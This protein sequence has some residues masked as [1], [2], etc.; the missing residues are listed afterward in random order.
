MLES[1]S[2]SR[3]QIR[4]LSIERFRGIESLTWIPDEGVN[5]ILGGGDAGKSTILDAI[6]LLL[7]PS[8]TFTLTEADYWRREV[9]KEFCIEAVMSIP[10]S[11]GLHSQSKNAWPWMWNGADAIV[12]DIEAK[13]SPQ[14]DDPVFRVRV[15]GTSDFDLLFEVRQPNDDL[16]HFSV[17]VRRAVGLV[18]LSSDDRNDRDLRLIQGS[19]LDR[20]LSDKTLRSRLGKLLG[21]SDVEAQLT[22]SAKQ[23]LTELDAA[24]AKRTLPNEL[25]LGL[26][27][28][29]GFSINALIGLTAKKDDVE[30]PLAVWGAG[31]RRLAALEVAAIHHGDNP[32]TVVDEAERGLEPYR[33]RVL[34]EDLEKSQSQVFLTTHSNAVLRAVDTASLWYMDTRGKVGR[35]P[36]KAAAHERRD[37]AIFLSRFA[38]V[39]EGI[40]EVGFVT[41]LLRRAIGDDLQRRGVWI[42]DAGGNDAAL[43][44]LDG[45]SKSGLKFAGFADDEGTHP[46]RWNAL[47]QTMQERLF[48]W[49]SGCLEENIIRTLDDSHLEQLIEDPTGEETGTRLRTLAFR[50]G[51]EDK[52]FSSIAAQAPDLKQ[53]I[54]EAATGTVPSGRV[55]LDKGEKKTYKN[56]AQCWFKNPKGGEELVA[57]V[58][59]LGLWPTL[60]PDLMPF[61]NSIRAELALEPIADLLP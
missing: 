27:G 47:K 41:A 52:T 4:K 21:A 29:Q 16:D 54:I 2:T 25:G 36:K 10:E 57:K 61:L 39:A 1:M 11:C 7:H 18:R 58:L 22:P 56:H 33:Q 48:R 30:L 28:T 60:R 5:V 13:G 53:L 19:A 9:D 17:A 50:L 34:V 51:I 59:K 49:K 8:N 43:D 20:L 37:P 14:N 6:S 26:S 46:G 31:T 32:I 3:P 44:L 24:F 15:R 42:S 23:K 55:D 45:L 38:V 40:T 12:P 35:L